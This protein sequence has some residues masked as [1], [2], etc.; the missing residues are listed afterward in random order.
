MIEIMNYIQ[1]TILILRLDA[2]LLR[3][4]SCLKPYISKYIKEKSGVTFGRTGKENLYEEKQ[5]LLKSSNM[6]VENIGICLISEC[7][8]HFNRLFKR[9]II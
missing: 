8:E 4:S 9:H 3:S 1:R 5:E 7:G 6:T 2:P